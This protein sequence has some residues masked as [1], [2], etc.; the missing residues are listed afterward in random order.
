MPIIEFDQDDID[1]S[2]IVTPSWYRVKVTETSEKVAKSG[3]STNYYMK[4]VIVKNADNGSTEFAGVPTPRNWLFNSQVRSQAV[5]F[6]EAVSKTK[7]K[8]GDRVELSATIGKE[9][10]IFFDNGT[11][12]NQLQNQIN[13]KYRPCKDA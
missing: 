7:M 5:L 8:A 6:V 13:H 4:G 12:N 2:K 9:L 3:T 1:G 11:Y 10:D